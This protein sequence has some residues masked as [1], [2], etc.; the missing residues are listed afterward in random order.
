MS[1]LKNYLEGE[2]PLNKK[3]N[4]IKQKLSDD[5]NMLNRLTLTNMWNEQAPMD[6]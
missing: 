6:L 4:T 2:S 3:L 5:T 1:H